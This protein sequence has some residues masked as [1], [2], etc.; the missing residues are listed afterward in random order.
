MNG[1]VFSTKNEKGRWSDTVLRK[2]F[3]PGNK[4]QKAGGGEGDGNTS[5]GGI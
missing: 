5:T 1:E 3:K 4:Y 2:S